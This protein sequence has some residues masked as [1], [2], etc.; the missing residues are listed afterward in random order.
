MPF[1]SIRNGELSYSAEGN[2]EPIVLLTGFGAD[3]EFWSSLMP[4]LSPEFTV[5][6][7]DNRGSG[8]TV[9]E[10]KF[11]IDDMADDVIALLDALSFGKAH[12]LGWSMGSQ[13]AQ[14]VAA[15]YPDRVH[16]LILVSS[17]FRRPERSAFMLDGMMEAVEKGMPLKYLGVPLIAMG[18]PES[19]FASK[20]R[21]IPETLSSG[22]EGMRNQMDAVNAYTTKGKVESVDM[23]VLSIHGVKDYMVPIEMGDE[24]A[25]SIKNCKKLRLEDEGHNILPSRY[26]SELKEFL[27]NHPI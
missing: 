22:I 20:K 11:T 27:K 2:G 25:D 21:D 17:Y 1:V 5:V 14:S 10:G 9:Y 7:V 19:Y 13:I 12:I 26:A 24:L 23:P 16:S 8:D 15:R 3:K 6:S 4:A 18:F